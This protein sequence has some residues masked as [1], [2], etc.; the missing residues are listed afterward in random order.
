[1][2]NESEKSFIYE[3]FQQEHLLRHIA[4]IARWDQSINVREGSL[5]ASINAVSNLETLINKNLLNFKKEFYRKGLCDYP[6]SKEDSRLFKEIERHFRVHCTL[7]EEFSRRKYEIISQ[8]ESE[9]VHCRKNNN[10]EKYKPILSEVVKLSREEASYR[11]ELMGCSNYNAL[12]DLYEPG[13]TSEQLDEIFYDLKHFCIPLIRSSLSGERV[14]EK[15]RAFSTH[16][17]QNSSIYKKISEIFGFDLRKGRIDF[18]EHPF[19]AGSPEDIRLILKK[20]SNIIDGIYAAI[21]ESGHACYEQNLPNSPTGLPTNF[22]KSVGIHES[23]SLFFETQIAKDKNFLFFLSDFLE[24][25]AG[26]KISH[27]ELYNTINTI[28]PQPIRINSDEISYILHIAI[29]YEIEK[30]LINGDLGVDDIPIVWSEKSLEYLGIDYGD[31]HSQGCLQDIHWSIGLFGYF[32]CYVLGSIYSA[33]LFHE[34]KSV[35]P[36]YGKGLRTGD[37]SHAYKWLKE[38]V[39]SKGSTIGIEDFFESSRN[40]LNTSP[41]KE[42]LHDRY[43][44]YF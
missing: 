31:D 35:Y 12:L 43:T 7:N 28:T 15:K 21:H 18:G 13:I 40:P 9:W 19:C 5:T 20:D 37:I 1:M 14:G 44:T 39:W 27:S 24:K 34:F 32:P 17:P 33:N 42:Y 23:Q 2:L 3:H 10:W 36:D 26:I 11:A 22:P 41:L 6:A 30:D 25:E 16:Y 38:K 8:S 29:R 4:E